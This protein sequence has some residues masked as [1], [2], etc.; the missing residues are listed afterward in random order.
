[1]VDQCEKVLDYE[2]NNVKCAF[3]MAQ[4]IM[5]IGESESHLKSALKWITIAH[6]NLSSDV[7]IKELYTEIK[8]K[9]EST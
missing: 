1:V 7:K 8:T 4:A 3:R 9:Y 2:P 6:E 5:Q